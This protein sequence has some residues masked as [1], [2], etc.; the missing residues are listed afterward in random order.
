MA[1]ILCEGWDKYGG[2]NSVTA[3]VSAMLMAGEW[4]SGAAN[5]GIVAPLSSTGQALQGQL[6]ATL[7]L[8]KTLP[9]SYGRLIGGIRFRVDVLGAAS[10]GIAFY[11]AGSVQCCVTVNGTTGTISLRNGGIAGTALATSGTSITTAAIHYLEWDITFGNSAAYQVWMDGVSLFSGTGDTTATANNTASQFVFIG[12]GTAHTI[13]WDDL[14][15]FDTTG[16]TNNAVLLT[17]PRIETT[18]P[19]S[20]SAVQFAVGAA[21][22]GTSIPRVTA[23]NAP[24]A[25]SLALRR[26]TPVVAGTLNS[27]TIMPGATSAGANYRGVVYA[28]SGG[29]APG[30]LMSSGTQV[31]GVTSGTATTLPLTTP[32]SLAA[33]TQYWLGFINDTSVVLQQSDGSALGYRAANTYASGAPSTAPAMTSGLPSWLLWGN[34]TSVSSNNWNM[35][36][37][38]PPPGIYSYVFD[39]TVAHEDLYI[40]NALSATPANVYAVAVKGYLQKSDSGTKTLSLRMKSGA[41]DSGG[42]L[43]G[44]APATTY[45]WAVSI[46]ETDPATSAAWTGSGLNAAT[47]G[48]RVDS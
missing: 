28:D 33:G 14:Y 40:F 42:S 35:S 9:A 31:T 12:G 8:V 10:G 4:T 26:F 30:T 16:S 20:D 37:Q 19:T 29:T 41:T 47:S 39:A 22:L 2:V 17:S 43:T 48:V 11:D 18:F 15:L 38:Q 6:T 7:S 25:A 45:G 23:T 32:Q 13:T 36:A 3:N 44:Q 34:M 21:I 5:F 24:A 46:F 27:V 1:L